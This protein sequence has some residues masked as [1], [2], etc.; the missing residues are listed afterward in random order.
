MGSASGAQRCTVS[1]NRDRGERAQKSIN[2]VAA[3]DV[4][5]GCAM[6]PPASRGGT[7]T[8]VLVPLHGIATRQDLPLPF[9]FVVVGAALAL[10]I[11]FVVLA[12]AWRTPRFSMLSGVPLPRLTSVVDH[13]VVRWAARLLRSEEHTSEL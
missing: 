8:S 11:S 5:F 2:P 1:S 10:I 4:G 3:S 13:S 7:V 12:F 6:G 9:T